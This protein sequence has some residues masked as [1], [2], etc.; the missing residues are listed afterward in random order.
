MRNIFSF[1]ATITAAS[2]AASFIMPTRQPGRLPVPGS[3]AYLQPDHLQFRHHPQ[4][5]PGPGVLRHPIFADADTG[6]TAHLI[7]RRFRRA[8]THGHSTAQR[9]GN[10]HQAAENRRRVDIR[11][12]ID[13]GHRHDIPVLSSAPAS[14]GSMWVVNSI[15]RRSRLMPAPAI[16]PT[17]ISCRCI[18]I[19]TP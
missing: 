8:D 13:V 19:S 1:S 18:A 4:Q 6:G 12:P 9:Q 7:H 15:S 14:E 5:C 3:A 11:H 2:A 10:H 17:A 16:S